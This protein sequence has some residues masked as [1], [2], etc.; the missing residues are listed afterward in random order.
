MP[1]ICRSGTVTAMASPVNGHKRDD[2]QLFVL[3]GEGA[4]ELEELRNLPSGFTL[5]GTG[6]PDQECKGMLQLPR[7]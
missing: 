1:T 3:S 4:P 5:L 6:R 2:I 7:G